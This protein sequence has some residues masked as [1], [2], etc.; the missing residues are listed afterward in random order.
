V[1]S[2]NPNGARK[3]F[4]FLRDCDQINRRYYVG[5]NVCHGYKKSAVPANVT[6]GFP[7][8]IKR[9]YD[10]LSPDKAMHDLLAAIMM[11]YPDKGVWGREMPV[12]VEGGMSTVPTDR[13]IYTLIGLK[14]YL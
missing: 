8:G 4:V 6:K 10:G 1:P 5:K 3:E 11:I 7:L 12:F 9:Y 13:E 2:F 14:E